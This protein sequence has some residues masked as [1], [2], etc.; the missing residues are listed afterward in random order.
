MHPLPTADEI[1][2]HYAKKFES[3]N[4]EIL[5]RFADSYRDVYREF[6][7]WIIASFGGSP[8]AIQGRKLLEVGCFTGEFLRLAKGAGFE[9]R[10]FELQDHAVRIAEETLPGVVTKTDV[11]DDNIAGHSYDVVCLFGVVEHVTDPR[12]LIKRSVEL[13]SPG[14]RIFIQTP[15]RNSWPARIMGAHWPPYAPVEHIHLM[16]GAALEAIL[17]ECGCEVMS[18]RPHWKRLP[19]EYVFEM[20]RHFGPEWRA[21]IAPFFAVLPRALRSVSLPFY[22]G[23]VFI[24]ARKRA[25]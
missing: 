25:E 19:V 22:I 2:S 10:G 11:D 7:A 6:L 20:L 21:L 18:M 14:G 15:D 3:G 13:L 17:S 8:A 9:V 16:T 23:E 12:R 24:E 4:Y 5:R 1:E